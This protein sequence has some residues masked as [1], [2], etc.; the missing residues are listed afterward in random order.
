M[1]KVRK[2]LIKSIMLVI[3]L[4]FGLIFGYNN[5]YSKADTVTNNVLKNIWI[6]KYN[7]SPNFNSNNFKYNLKVFSKDIIIR[8]EKMFEEQE[9]FISDKVEDLRYGQNDIII[10]VIY[11]HEITRYNLNIRLVN[12]STKNEAL[13]LIGLIVVAISIAIFSGI[14]SKRTC[15]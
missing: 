15:L 12:S 5:N 1:T 11:N 14:T 8:Y 2:I 3:V 7:L 10:T 13:V 4:S 6:E 9:V